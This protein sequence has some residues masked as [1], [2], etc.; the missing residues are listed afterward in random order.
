MLDTNFT[1]SYAT[2]FGARSR[3]YG[4]HPTS[5]LDILA[6]YRT[7]IEYAQDVAI[8]DGAAADVAK[9]ILAR[10]FQGLWMRPRM[11]GEL[12]SAVRVIAARGFWPEGW[13]AVCETIRSEGKYMPPE[14]L[15]LLKALEADCRPTDL[16]ETARAYIFSDPSSSPGVVDAEPGAEGED[17][18]SAYDRAMKTTELLGRQT[19]ADTSVLKKLLPDLVRG[20]FGRA[21]NFGRGL[22][23]GAGSVDSIW[24]LLVEALA[25]VPKAERNVQVLHGFLN[26][27]GSRD[28]VPTARFLD[29]TVSDPILG[30][31]FPILQTAVDIDDM[32][33]K[34]LE[35]ALR[36]K[37]A[38]SSAYSRLSFTCNAIPPVRLRPIVLGIASLPDGYEVAVNTL[39]MYLHFAG[40]AVAY[41]DTDLIEC[42]RDLLK[43][44]SFA[45]PGRMIDHYL[46]IIAD[47]SLKGE[48]GMDDALSIC[49]RL[50]V[51]LSDYRAYGFQYLGLAS[52]LFR[53]QPA[54]ALDELVGSQQ[55]QGTR[56]WMLDFR[57]R[58]PLMQAPVESVVAWAQANPKVRFPLLAPI[59]TPFEENKDRT[60]LNWVPMA[61]RILDLA[62]DKGPV[63]DAFRGHIRRSVWAGSGLVNEPE[64][65]RAL[66]K[67]LLSDP[68]AQIVAWAKREDAELAALAKT[69]RLQEWRTDE[70]FE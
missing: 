26:A 33:T 56:F 7:S 16:I 6:W 41:T 65:R 58:N 13:I 37:L 42:G 61:L 45:R 44:C 9:S 46:G 21:W 29:A 14:H 27:A 11:I 63:L 17:A 48:G 62:P 12:E 35:E 5:E 55:G 70:G 54:I 68:D 15:V 8:S 67:A 3:D 53:V 52:A 69:Q 30:P 50:K 49:R 18:V 59:I 23:E 57:S 1:S 66:T 28:P 22:A 40:G 2:D 39:A 32:G 10:K 24:R 36:L 34:R 19:A 60:E 31:F 51:A 43:R 64:N 38:P 20:S 25:A 4:W 47:F